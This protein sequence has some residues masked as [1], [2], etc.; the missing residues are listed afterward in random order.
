MKTIACLSFEV[1]NILGRSFFFF[2]KKVGDFLLRKRHSLDYRRGKD[3]N[4]VGDELR[5]METNA[6]LK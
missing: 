6:F 4:G 1:L 3:E 2:N 5:G